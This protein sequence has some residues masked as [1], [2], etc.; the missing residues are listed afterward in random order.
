M[1]ALAKHPPNRSYVSAARWVTGLGL[2][3]RANQALALLSRQRSE[4][5]SVLA[6]Q[7]QGQE[8]AGVSIIGLDSPPPTPLGSPVGVSI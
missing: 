5:S 3:V 4:L 6:P 8:N 7:P 2:Q 1:Y